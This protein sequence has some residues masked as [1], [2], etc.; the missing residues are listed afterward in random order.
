ML[1]RDDFKLVSLRDLRRSTDVDGVSPPPSP[2]SP[3]PS[4]FVAGFVCCLFRLRGFRVGNVDVTLILQ[5]PKV[6]MAGKILTI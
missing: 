1:A 3:P 4:L 6:G 5:K 2:P